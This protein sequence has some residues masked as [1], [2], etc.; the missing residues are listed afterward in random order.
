MASIPNFLILEHRAE[1]VPWRYEVCTELPV[2]G[3]YIDVPRRPG[4]GVEIDEDVCRAHPGVH[5]V[6]VVTP[7]NLERMYVEPR[8]KRRRVFERE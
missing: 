1:D 4:L 6:A 7:N 3:G 5:N 2:V 8:F